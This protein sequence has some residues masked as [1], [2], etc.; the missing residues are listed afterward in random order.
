MFKNYQFKFVYVVTMVN[1]IHF[2]FFLDF[3]GSDELVVGVD[4]VSMFIIV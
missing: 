4:E 1:V 2:Y 3:K